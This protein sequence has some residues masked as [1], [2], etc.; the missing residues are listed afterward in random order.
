[1]LEAAP[2]SGLPAFAA[3]ADVQPMSIARTLLRVAV[4][5][6]FA[7]NGLLGILAHEATA[8]AFARFGVPAPGATAWLAGATQIVC[9]AMFAAGILTRAVGL[10]LATLA[11]AMMLTAGRV[12]GGVYLLIPAL[13]FASSVYL[14]WD[15]GRHGGH[16]PARRP[17][18]Q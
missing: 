11:V 7:L 13:L 9:G 4:G 5:L 14:A 6:L 2:R 18:V 17:G 16:L 1:V 15:S 10:I 3:E 12:A 8:L